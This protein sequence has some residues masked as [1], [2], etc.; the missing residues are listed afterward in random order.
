MYLNF[1]SVKAPSARLSW[2]TANI[3]DQKQQYAIHINHIMKWSQNTIQHLR[4][5]QPIRASAGAKA[6]H[7]N[8]SKM[9]ERLETEITALVLEAGKIES[10][11]AGLSSPNNVDHTGRTVGNVKL[12]SQTLVSEDGFQMEVSRETI[13]RYQVSLESGS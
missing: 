10:E 11:M 1:S 9:T 13:Q 6:T 2:L 3:W 5:K 12:H 4:K 8:I 7:T